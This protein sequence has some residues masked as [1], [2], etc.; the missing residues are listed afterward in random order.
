MTKIRQFVVVSLLLTLGMSAQAASVLVK[1]NKY[2]GMGEIMKVAI[3][4]G[5]Y[6]SASNSTSWAYIEEIDTDLSG[7]YVHIVS[8][9]AS[10]TRYGF[11]I[12]V[13]SKST[14]DWSSWSARRVA[15]TAIAGEA[16]D[17][18]PEITF[19]SPEVPFSNPGTG[20][21][22]LSHLLLPFILP[23]EQKLLVA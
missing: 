11:R 19:T 18:M 1:I 13:R 4:Y 17:N 8:N 3:Q 12:R 23:T 2:T 20:D 7:D 15:R 14:G 16:E 6:D 22:V 9:L 21:L 10:D 5:T